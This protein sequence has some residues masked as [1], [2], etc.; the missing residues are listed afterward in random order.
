MSDDDW[1]GRTLLALHR[2]T[3]EACRIRSKL[4]L[5]STDLAEAATNMQTQLGFDEIAG[6]PPG[7]MATDEQIR[8]LW[9]GL[10]SVQREIAA[11][12][13]DAQSIV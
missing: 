3:S 5:I 13:R 12:Q 10:I 11:L 6:E 8:Q 2:K 7:G 4:A 1:A 9:D